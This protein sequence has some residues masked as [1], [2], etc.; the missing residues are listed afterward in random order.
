M[1]KQMALG[2]IAADIYSH[3]D[4]FNSPYPQWD[5]GTVEALIK[6][7]ERVPGG[8]LVDENDLSNTMVPQY[9][10]TKDDIKYLRSL[11]H[12]TYGQMARTEGTLGVAKATGKT[13]WAFAKAM[14][15]G[16]K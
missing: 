14:W 7:L 11:A 15:K 16:I 1:F 8:L 2:R 13:A 9:F 4:F 6:A 3:R 10:F 5:A 12:V